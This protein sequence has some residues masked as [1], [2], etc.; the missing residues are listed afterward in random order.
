MLETSRSVTIERAQTLTGY[1]ADA[2]R[3]KIKRGDWLEGGVWRRAPD[4]RVLI[5]MEGYEAWV[6]GQPQHLRQAFVQRPSARSKS[7][8][9]T[10]ASAA[11]S[12]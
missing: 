12:D 1:T 4:G 3:A 10:K 6:E 8:S 9:I 11:A 5:D 2:I 7:T